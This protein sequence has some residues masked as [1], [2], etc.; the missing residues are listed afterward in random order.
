MGQNLVGLLNLGSTALGGGMQVGG[1][2][3]EAF[4]A[5]QQGA[6]QAAVLKNNALLANEAAKAALEAGR[7]AVQEKQIET[8]QTIG[9][10]RTALAGR[11]IVVGQDTADIIAAD[12]ARIGK[13]D[14]QTIQ[15]NAERQA[16]AYRLQG[17]NFSTE[18]KYAKMQGQA[19]FM[20]G[21]FG[22]FGTLLST[23][24]KVAAKWKSFQQ[25][26]SQGLG[27]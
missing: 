21:L 15:R 6:F 12:V 5:K 26:Q 1:A 18:A 27:N 8:A 11:G 10:Q 14:Q 9:S 2:I 3:T 4:G 17:W 22:S 13:M 7:V 16:L 19:G 25:T 23:A 20:S 24:G